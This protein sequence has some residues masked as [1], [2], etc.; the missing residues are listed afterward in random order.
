ML[1]GQ[2]IA[3]KEN[4]VETNENDANPSQVDGVVTAGGRNSLAGADNQH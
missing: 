1:P 3:P 4:I 2:P